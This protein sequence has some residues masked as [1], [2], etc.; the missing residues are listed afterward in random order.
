MLDPMFEDPRLQWIAK[1]W[2]NESD[3][4]ANWALKT[5]VNRYDVWGQYTVRSDA[6]GKSVGAVTLPIKELRGKGDMVSFDKLKRH[7]RGRKNSDLIGLH[8]V[9]QEDTCL[10]FAIDLDVHEEKDASY[11]AKINFNAATH[12]SAFFRSKLLDPCII[13]SNGWGSLHLLVLLDRP[14]PLKDVYGFLE[15]ACS[16]YPELDLPRKPEYFPSSETVENLGKWLRMP[17]RHHTRPHFSKVWSDDLGGKWMEGIEAIE[18]LLNLAPMPLPDY[19]I[20]KKPGKKVEKSEKRHTVCVDLDK[21]LAKYDGWK[22]L[23]HIGDPIPG[24]R[25]F[26]TELANSY[27]VVIHTARFSNERVRNEGDIQRVKNIIEVWLRENNL[28]FDEVFTGTG[29]PLASAFVDD[30]AVN[31]QPEDDPEEYSRTLLAIK[32]LTQRNS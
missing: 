32:E 21:V 3:N 14:Y 10:W 11:L 4:L 26:L 23:E 16:D 25:E 1:E 2:D 17:G 19:K 7:F 18:A 12:W 9:S 6:L 29:K 15:S 20:E 13:E 22:S 27:R 5:L 8:C 31:C 28:D 24:A 30:R